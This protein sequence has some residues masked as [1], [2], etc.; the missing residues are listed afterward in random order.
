MAPARVAAM[1]RDQDVAVRHVGQLVGQHA[2]EL[3]LVEDPHDPLGHGHHRVL[4]VAA[5]G[6]GVGVS[7]GIR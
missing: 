1:R 4:G 5:G 3:F 7:V 2:L 6:E